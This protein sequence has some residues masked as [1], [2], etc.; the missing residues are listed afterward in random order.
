MSRWRRPG[1]TSTIEPAVPLL[2]PRIS[3]TSGISQNP[4][5]I[6]Y[7]SRLQ[8]AQLRAHKC[9]INFIICPVQGCFTTFSLELVH[10]QNGREGNTFRL[11]SVDANLKS[12]AR[13]RGCPYGAGTFCPPKSWVAG[14]RCRADTGA[15]VRARHRPSC[16]RLTLLTHRH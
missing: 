5:S 8:H 4:I 3:Q 10:H 9:H 16:N 11:T 2:R 14:L 7:M 6:P 15:P 12:D 1:A 13:Q